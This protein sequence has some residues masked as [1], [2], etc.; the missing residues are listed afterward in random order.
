MKNDTYYF[1]RH[2]LTVILSLE[3]YPQDIIDAFSQAFIDA[4]NKQ[5]S[6]SPYLA[7]A[8]A[9]TEVLIPYHNPIQT[10]DIDRGGKTT[11]IKVIKNKK[12]YIIDNLN[13]IETQINTITHN[14]PNIISELKLNT[15]SVF[16]AGA[17][18]TRVKYWEELLK[19]VTL[20][21]TLSSVLPQL[22]SLTGEITGLYTTKTGDSINI[23]TDVSSKKTLVEPLKSQLQ[24]C[25]FNTCIICNKDLSKVADFFKT[26]IIDGREKAQGF[27][28]IN[29]FMLKVL[30]GM[31]QS[32][33][34]VKYNYGD[35]FKIDGLGKGDAM[36]F[37]SNIPNPTVIPDYAKLAKAGETTIV[38]TTNIGTDTQFYLIIAAVTPGE[39]VELKLTVIP[40]K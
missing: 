39:D 11:D 30:A 19:N 3:I 25:F 18:A 29:E 15:K 33:P 24:L 23:S 9:L 1:L 17:E 20:K 28:Y 35:S 14:D 37:L 5:P 36:I 6:G 10:T 26:D 2:A 22:T 12:Q 21:T 38:K 34:Q 13:D 4:A 16:Y 8:T 31:F 40:K 7:L 27:L 32:C